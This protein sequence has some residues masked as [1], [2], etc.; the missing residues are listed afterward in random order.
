MNIKDDLGSGRTGCNKYIISSGVKKM[1]RIMT[2]N[3]NYYGDRYGDWSDRKDIIVDAIQKHHPQIVALQAVKRDPNR[4]GG[5]DQAEQLSRALP[6]YPHFTYEPAI[7][8][9]DGSA[10]GNAFLSR[11]RILETDYQPMTFIPGLDD[12][13]HRIVLHGLF[14]LPECPLNLF[15]AHFSWVEAQTEVNLPEALTY[16][17]CFKGYKII[18]GDLNTTPN[19]KLLESLVSE[20]WTD[21]WQ[22]MHPREAGFTFESG[23]PHLRIDYI[24]SDNELSSRIAAAEIVANQPGPTGAYASDHFGLLASFEDW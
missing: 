16:A 3:L 4:Y 5:L 21:S 13:N 20:D 22:K 6:D 14:D 19:S 17:Q 24:W 11:F 1:L 9:P 18:L 2:L 10:D 8:H 23:N 12:P 7:V 15:N